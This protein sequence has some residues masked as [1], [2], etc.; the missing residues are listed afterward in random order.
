[1][2]SEAPAPGTSPPT[3]EIATGPARTHN[4][5]RLFVTV[6]FA[7]ACPQ[8]AYGIVGYFAALQIQSFDSVHKI[9]KLAL[10]H[11]AVATASMIAQPLVGVL[12]DRTR[13]R[14]GGH[15]GFRCATDHVA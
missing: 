10:V 8:L 6:P 5:R 3:G 9:E 2:R 4:L 12:S 7:S 15:T 13:T 1:M 11:A 14:F